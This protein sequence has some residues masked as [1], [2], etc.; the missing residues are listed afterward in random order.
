MN[1]PSLTSWPALGWLLLAVFLAIAFWSS[2]RVA[3][4]HRRGAGVR[5]GDIVYVCRPWRLA[6][7]A[8]VLRCLEQSVI[9]DPVCSSCTRYWCETQSHSWERRHVA[10]EHVRLA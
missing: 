2:W 4:H 8:V 6:Y 9:V 10:L 1:G 5:P 7:R 3:S